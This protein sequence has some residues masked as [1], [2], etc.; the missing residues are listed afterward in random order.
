MNRTEYVELLSKM[1]SHTEKLQNEP[2]KF[3][4]TEFLIAEIVKAELQDCKH[5]LIEEVMF[6]KGR[7]NLIIKYENFNSHVIDD[8]RTL[9]FVGSH[10]DV[11]PAN[12]EEWKHN[13]FELTVDAKDPDILWGRGTTDCLG[14]VALLVQ[15]LKDLSKNNVKLDYTIGVVL[16]ADEECGDDP[17]VGVSNLS[18]K[19][20][21]D[22]LKNGPVYW[23]DE[24]DTYP[25][26]GSG[27]MMSWEL[28]TYGKR[29][30]SGMTFNTIN[31]ILLS[32]QVIQSMLKVFK[33]NFPEHPDEEKYCYECTSN[34]KPTQYV[35]TE[36]SI[37][38][39]PKF[40]WT[41]GYNCTFSDI[42]IS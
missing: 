17:T 6:V 26:V 5:I 2:P 19:G 3:I 38:A 33:D 36:G 24:A 20:Y 13:P 14:H 42:I 40:I 30:H 25:V 1:I 39:V 34:M 37:I 18:K 8:T 31:P 41:F 21:L 29:G 12:P 15:M 9:G 10:M 16:I 22:F 35:N 7:P 4:P 23:L 32:F 27:T 11:V 28:T